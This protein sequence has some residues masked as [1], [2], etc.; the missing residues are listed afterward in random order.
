MCIYWNITRFSRNFV[1]LNLQVWSY[2]NPDR[3]LANIPG[4]TWVLFAASWCNGSPRGWSPAVTSS[5]GCPACREAAATSASP[6]R[7]GWCCWCPAQSPRIWWR[8]SWWHWCSSVGVDWLV[9]LSA[10]IAGIWWPG[11]YIP[12]A[13]RDL[14]GAAP[15]P[16]P[17]YVTSSGHQHQ[18]CGREAGARAVWTQS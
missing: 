16:A 4:L 12:Q 3:D 8:P 14:R 7:W 9:L 10:L 2:G 5:P 13:G 1:Q 6:R 18:V 11:V 17:G 15:A